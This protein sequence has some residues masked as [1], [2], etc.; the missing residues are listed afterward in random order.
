MVSHTPPPPPRQPP[1]ISLTGSVLEL[2][3]YQ[4]CASVP[5]T[6]ELKLGCVNASSVQHLHGRERCQV[7]C[8]GQVVSHESLTVPGGLALLYSVDR[9]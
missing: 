8:W 9:K 7:L 6:H 3:V 5:C 2:W 4:A 1:W